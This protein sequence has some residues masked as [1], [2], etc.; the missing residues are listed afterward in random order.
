[1]SVDYT[2]R[3]LIEDAPDLLRRLGVRSEG[4]L[5][6]YLKSF[7]AT[8]RNAA[9]ELAQPV[10]REL[11][12]DDGLLIRRGIEEQDLAKSTR[13]MRISVV[14]KFRA[15]YDLAAPHNNT[16]TPMDFASMLSASLSA[17][18]RRDS[19]L[20]IAA[21]ARQ[22]G[23][24]TSSL[25]DW[26]NDKAAPHGAP[27]RVERLE[28]ALGAAPGSL[29]GRLAPVPRKSPAFCPTQTFPEEWRGSQHAQKEFR[30]RV[31]KLLPDVYPL[32]PRPERRTLFT[33]A[34]A[35]E[36]QRLE[37]APPPFTRYCKP[38]HDWPREAQRE[39]DDYVKFKTQRRGRNRTARWDSDKSREHYERLVMSLYGWWTSRSEK[40][41]AQFARV[42]LAL[43]L[44]PDL[45]MDF[46]E[47]RSERSG[48]HYNGMSVKILKFATSL[49]RRDT[50]W[51]WQNERLLDAIPHPALIELCDKLDDPDAPRLVPLLSSRD[52]RFWRALCESAYERLSTER[53]ETEQIIKDQK[54]ESSRFQPIAPILEMPAPLD[55]L[56][57]ALKTFRQDI[58]SCEGPQ[59]DRLFMTY[60]IAR[61]LSVCPLRR[62]HFEI[63]T[64][65]EDGSGHILVGDEEVRMQAQV[66]E[67][68]NSRSSVFENDHMDK[69]MKI[70][71]PRDVQEDIRT[72][73][74][75]VRPRMMQGQEHDMAFV[76]P[77]SGAPAS[78]VYLADLIR[79][80]FSAV[81]L[82]AGGGKASCIAGVDP[83]GPH[84]FRHIV[85][86]DLAKNYGFDAAAAALFDTVRSIWEQYAYVSASDN[87]AITMNRV[88]ADR[89]R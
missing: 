40:R 61:I 16:A 45:V 83:F 71:L 67:F 35:R 79:T 49:L 37:K 12:Q 70:P 78:A 8:L 86:T 22:T 82:A 68:K 43:L 10:D 34:V 88:W 48:G 74:F 36:K 7:Q 21:L 3:D 44:D 6:G 87:Y 11:M 9:I 52:V 13:A 33:K 30:R 23:I 39:W 73:L 31:K 27:K 80:G 4:S 55:A 25:R 19:T 28:A 32:L 17:A 20:T 38:Y 42:S 41:N 26:I 51:L 56:N 5:T 89:K 1:M 58:D 63:A 66:Q 75:E 57:F 72:Y 46:V 77:A 62:R 24:P 64:Y 85:A 47:F 59:Q 84:A 60:V 65:R 29:S 76:V 81:Y 50:G 14:R 54:R 18:Q 53:R 69:W 2:Y 15:A